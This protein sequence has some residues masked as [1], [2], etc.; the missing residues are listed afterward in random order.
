MSFLP[1]DDAVEVRC[2]LS[3]AE[4][5]P[6]GSNEAS[7]NVAYEFSKQILESISDAWGEGSDGSESYLWFRMRPAQTVNGT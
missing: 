4:N 2:N 3:P 7:D 6:A 5:L 1:S